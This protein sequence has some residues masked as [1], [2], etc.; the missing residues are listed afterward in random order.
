MP[1]AP[2]SINLNLETATV[3][4]R[5]LAGAGPDAGEASLEYSG[6]G[7]TV[8]GKT[9]DLK[10]TS[11]QGSEAGAVDG[12][13]DAKF[14]KL[15][16]IRVKAGKSVKLK[17]TLLDQA[18][19]EEV[20]PDRFEIT[21][22][23]IGRG[24]SMTPAIYA[25]GYERYFTSSDFEYDIGPATHSRT[26]FRA[27]KRLL[28]CHRP[29]NEESLDPVNCGGLMVDNAKRAVMLQYAGKSSFEIEFEVSCDR[30]DCE[31]HGRDL[32]FGG[33]SDAVAAAGSSLMANLRC[34]PVSCGRPPHVDNALYAPGRIAFP[35][36]VSYD[37]LPGFSIDGSPQGIRDFSV[38]CLADGT[39]TAAASHEC[40]PMLFQVDGR[41]RD[42]SNNHPIAD[43]KVEIE[44][45]SKEA[46]FTSWDGRYS[47]MLPARNLSLRI[48]KA[49]YISYTK[50]LTVQGTLTGGMAD[51]SLSPVLP[52][53]GW[54]AVL[55]WD[56]EPYDLDSHVF[57]HGTTCHTWYADPQVIC[58]SKNDIKI[59]LDVDDMESY[60]PETITFLDAE[61]CRGESSCR[62]VYK[63]H[64]YSQRPG[65]DVSKAQVVVYKGDHVKATYKIGD[66]G[67][68]SGEEDHHNQYWS[69]FALDFTKDEIMTCTTALCD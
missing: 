48:S 1:P 20:A 47:A 28:R 6:I 16:R 7:A 29:D 53:G 26:V 19:G 30:G 11:V 69:V 49:G 61:K 18:N 32:I 2:R 65:L 42:A 56:E 43:A 25:S 57:V 52:G 46:Q 51:I 14:E 10:I 24:P 62:L 54:R 33:R 40:K 5:N 60:G 34:V 22:L 44:V 23:G 8:D 3:K 68:V 9:L 15:G 13:A 64:N 35:K 4:H 66:A 36:L 31:G 55:T 37:C 45:G 12:T 39:F 58:H 27:T 63:V 38:Q 50:Q 17:F 59:D 67:V 21:F 41:V